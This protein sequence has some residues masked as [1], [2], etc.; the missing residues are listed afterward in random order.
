MSP[1]NGIMFCHGRQ[2]KTS[3]TNHL[4]EHKQASAFIKPEKQHLVAQLKAKKKQVIC[5]D[6]WTAK[7]LA[8]KKKAL[9]QLV[10]SAEAPLP[11][12]VRIHF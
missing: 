11:M 9:R 1:R 10:D 8:A 2:M 5:L 7:Q 3:T 6:R 4:T 12:L